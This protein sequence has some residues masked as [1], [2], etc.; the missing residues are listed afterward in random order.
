MRLTFSFLILLAS[1]NCFAQAEGPQHLDEVNLRVQ[2][3]GLGS[4]YSLVRRQLGTPLSSKREK[5]V[6]KFEVC[7]PSYTSL[8][9]GY[10]GVVVKL[11]SDLRSR[12]FKVISMEVTS[13]RLLIAP[14]IKIGMTEKEVRS[15]LGVPFQERNDSGVHILDYNTKENDGGAGFHFIGR[16]LMKVEWKYVLC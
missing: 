15:K 3:V 13:P 10:R 2:G 16:R 1:G 12:N 9:L 8:R 4:S 5:I 7:G 6:D 11:M 14:G